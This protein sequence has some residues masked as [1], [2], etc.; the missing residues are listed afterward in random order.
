M[1]LLSREQ[2]LAAS[3][4][5]REV[6]EVPEWG[7]EVY[8]RVL[9]GVERDQFEASCA[10]DEQGTR[11]FRARLCALCMVG[12]DGNRLFEFGEAQQLGAK[13]GQ[14]L[15]RVFDVARRLNGMSK[16]AIEEQEKNSA[17]DRNGSSGSS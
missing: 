17:P 5:A 8:V 11:N 2:I 14:A 6:V 7:G 10:D 12:E 3:D 13:S 1:G 15:D 9:T 4:L 16:D